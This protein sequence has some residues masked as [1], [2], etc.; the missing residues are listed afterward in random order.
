MASDLFLDEIKRCKN[1]GLG[2]SRPNQLLKVLRASLNY[3]INLGIDF[4]DLT[5]GIQKLPVDV[6][7][8]FIPTEEMIEAVK[9]KCNPDQK[10][11]IQFVYETGARINE[12][13][14]LDYEDVKKDFVVLYTRKSRNSQRVPRYVP[15]P[16]IIEP[17]GEGKV[18]K[19]WYAYPRFLE[20]K[21][22]KLGQ[23]T[24]NWHGLRHRRASIW[25]RDGKP[26]FELQMLLGHT[27][28]S[29]TQ[30]YLHSLGIVR[31]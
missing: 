30:R 28:I 9:S 5:R 14:A 27:Q 18:F 7:V 26:L 2:N 12:A 6:K 8:K 20:R 3:A 19:E 15:I 16:D 29:T 25:A 17:K 31:F 13:V 24:W 1:L 21:I 22:K 10:K 4:R 11:I 23:P